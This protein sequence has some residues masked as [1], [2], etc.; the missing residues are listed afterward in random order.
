MPSPLIAGPISLTAVPILL[1]AI[2]PITFN[3]P[4]KAGIVFVPN[5]AKACG[6]VFKAKFF[7]AGPMVGIVFK[8]NAFNVAPI[9]G[10]VF[11]AN[12]FNTV[13]A[14]CNAVPTPRSPQT[15]GFI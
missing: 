14:D 3:A 12:V 4:P 10:N 7:H 5:F 11:V 6:T 2:R 13:P 9:A 15:A 8:A 1:I